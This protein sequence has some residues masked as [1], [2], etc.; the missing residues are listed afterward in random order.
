MLE[1]TS[2]S[3]NFDLLNVSDLSKNKKS[4]VKVRQVFMSPLHAIE[5]SHS[6]KIGIF[7]GLLNEYNTVEAVVIIVQSEWVAGMQR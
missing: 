1:P 6:F 7:Y 5:D 2:H 3:F 4:K